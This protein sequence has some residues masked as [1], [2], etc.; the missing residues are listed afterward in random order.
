MTLWGDDIVGPAS[1]R[2]SNRSRLVCSGFLL[3]FAFVALPF[4]LCS[5]LAPFL[6]LFFSSDDDEA[7]SSS[8]E[9]LLP[10]LSS[11]SGKTRNDHTARNGKEKVWQYHFA[12]E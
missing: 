9:L 11:D 10:L 7:L 12:E 2:L 3:G 8:L 4:V 6:F 5:I 1:S